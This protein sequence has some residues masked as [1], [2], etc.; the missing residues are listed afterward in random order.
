[1]RG[2][3]AALR[4]ERAHLAGSAFAC[5]A[6]RFQL[7][8]D[9]LH[10]LPALGLP[11]EREGARQRRLDY[12]P[13]CGP[14]CRLRV[15]VSLGRADGGGDRGGALGGSLNRPESS[16]IVRKTSLCPVVT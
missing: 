9:P 13:A 15:S 1:M 11:G 16:R 8:G 14:S 6:M 2:A 4:V 10:H 12:T 3:L 7:P 5:Q